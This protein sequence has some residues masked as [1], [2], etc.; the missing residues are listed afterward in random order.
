M[1]DNMVNADAATGAESTATE[2]QATN[3]SVK[4]FTQ[5]EV[6]KIIAA[7]LAKVEN[8]YADIDVEEYRSF[9][10]A[11]A[12]QEEDALLKR[13]EF[14]KVLNQT[15]DHYSSQVNRLK[16]ELEAIKVDGAIVSAASQL[17][18]VAPDH[19]A[20]LLKTS[21]RLSEDGSVEVLDDKGQVRYNPASASPLTVDELVKEFV[22]K[23]PFYQAPGPVGSGSKSNLSAEQTKKIN[24][25]DLDMKNPE[26]RKV[27]AE[28]RKSAGL[29]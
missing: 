3:S 12:K 17:K 1:Q 5:D 27:Y 21:V 4:T 14:D 2:S 15:K 9:K 25:A 11:K 16:Q 29:A 10:S 6:N 18:V 24:V 20:K 26:H 28:Y 19:V 7:R 22:S 23:N 13:N 8:K